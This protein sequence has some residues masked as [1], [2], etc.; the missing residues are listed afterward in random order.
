MTMKTRRGL[1]KSGHKGVWLATAAAGR[2]LGIDGTQMESALG[3]AGSMASGL[4][5]FSQDPERTMV[6]RLHGGLGAH[7]GVLAAE[8]ASA[9]FNGPRDILEGEF[10]YCLSY[11][12]GEPALNEL[13]R[14]LGERFLILE[15][16]V[17]PYSSWGGAHNA[18]DA[19]DLILA[20]HPIP[21][22]EIAS[23]RIGGSRRLL[24]GHGMT[25]PTSIMAAQY[26][27]PFVTAIAL[28]HG[29]SS[30]VDPM[31]IWS[32]ETLDDERVNRIVDVTTLVVEDDLEEASINRRTYGG[33][34]V[35]VKTTSGDEV[36]AVVMDSKGTIGNPMSPEE[37][38]RKFRLLAGRALSPE[39]AEAIVSLVSS[40]EKLDDLDSLGEALRA[41]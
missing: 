14:G 33:A 18:I 21:P 11:G 29:P 15:R 6:K 37:V 23:V 22:D 5:Q 20:G 9:G 19:V 28:A 16:E 4:F 41:D 27:L 34:R 38:E 1:H 2:G 40:L 24:Q 31:A 32:K 30:L 26:S 12:E 17:K 13:T 39:K 10:G 35:T 8:L 7:N 25:R 3:L 36:Q